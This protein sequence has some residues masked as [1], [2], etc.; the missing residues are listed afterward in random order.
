MQKEV[1]DLN[2]EENLE[3]TKLV[4]GLYHRIWG[5]L[6]VSDLQARVINVVFSTTM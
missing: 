2:N 1:L 4:A 6:Q 3:K 5:I